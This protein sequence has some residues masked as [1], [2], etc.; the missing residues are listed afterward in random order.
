[1]RLRACRFRKLTEGHFAATVEVCGLR[2]SCACAK[3]VLWYSQALV[4]YAPCFAGCPW[5]VRSFASEQTQTK[6]K[7]DLYADRFASRCL[8][9]CDSAWWSTTFGD[10]LNLT[11]RSDA[12]SFFHS[13]LRACDLVM[14]HALFAQKLS[15]LSTPYLSWFRSAKTRSPAVQIWSWKLQWIFASASS[16]RCWTARWSVWRSMRAQHSSFVCNRLTS[17]L[18]QC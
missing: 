18:T 15:V 16:D 4:C 11:L 1:M 8:G 3:C 2:P 5:V 13:F 10:Q 9:I 12:S 7:D 14:I 17:R 6:T